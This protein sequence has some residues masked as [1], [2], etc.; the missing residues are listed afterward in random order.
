MGFWK[1]TYQLVLDCVSLGSPQAI[2]IDFSIILLV[3]LILPTS[4]LHVLPY[5]CVF[6]HVILPFVFRGNCPTSGLFAECN[7]PGCGLTRGIS[8]LLHLDFAGAWEY[9]PLSFAVLGVMVVLLVV[10]IKRSVGLYKATGA[11]YRFT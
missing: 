3:L 6:K 7:C 2:V 9:N 4:S 1:R 11:C 10:N 8:R 5:R